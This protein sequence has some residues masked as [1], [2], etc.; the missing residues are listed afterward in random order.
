MAETYTFTA[1]GG[2]I[3]GSDNAVIPTDATLPDWRDYEAWAATAGNVTAVYVAPVAKPS[4]VI[5]FVAFTELFTAAEQAA[6]FDASVAWQVRMFVAQATSAGP[7]L[8]LVD[9]RI[10]AGVN[11]LVSLLPSAVNFTAARAAQVLA[12][13]APPIS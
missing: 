6:I 8:D 11:S 5:G 4:T 12:N 1:T 9:S 3:R 10:I 2:V 13:Q 7:S